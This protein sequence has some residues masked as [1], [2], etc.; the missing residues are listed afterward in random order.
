MMV[1]GI[2]FGFLQKEVE[3]H[4]KQQIRNVDLRKIAV[5]ADLVCAVIRVLL[6]TSSR[7]FV[8]AGR[9]E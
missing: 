3:Q 1:C 2:N 6:D 7:Y 9:V 4:R 5:F 8:P